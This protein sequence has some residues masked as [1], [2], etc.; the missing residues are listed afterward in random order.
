MMNDSTRDVTESL[1]GS[2]VREPLH[3]PLCPP[4]ISAWKTGDCF[5]CDL[6]AKVRADERQQISH[7]LRTDAP[8]PSEEASAWAYGYAELIEKEMP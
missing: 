6:I 4:T 8:H 5:Y 2:D 3:D 7:W 1:H